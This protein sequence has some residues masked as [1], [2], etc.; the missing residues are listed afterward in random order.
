MSYSI[1]NR[2]NRKHLLWSVF[3]DE[4]DENFNIS[5]FKICEF[6]VCDC[7]LDWIIYYRSGN[8]K[9]MFS[10]EDMTDFIDR[11]PS[12]NV[13]SDILLLFGKNTIVCCRDAL[14]HFLY[15]KDVELGKMSDKCLGYES[16]MRCMHLFEKM[17]F[18]FLCSNCQFN[19]IKMVSKRFK[20]IKND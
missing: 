18:P 8:K 2:E 12:D 3:D 14:Y 17:F 4:D 15:K 10:E 6:R 1:Y 9:L 7:F 5:R 13:S 16:D 11:I 19:F 20:I